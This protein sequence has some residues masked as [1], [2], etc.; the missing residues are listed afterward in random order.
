MRARDRRRV[1]TCYDP[2]GTFVGER[3]LPVPLH[4][5]QALFGLGPGDE[6]FGT[7]AVG[8]A[9]AAR[10]SELLGEPLDL[11]AWTYYVESWEGEP[12]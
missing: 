9:Q 1:L 5:L 8:N 3:P 6:M 10:L 7:F 11:Q 2:D 4:E 12:D